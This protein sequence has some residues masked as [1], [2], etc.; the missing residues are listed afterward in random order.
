M[1]KII[2]AAF[3]A[4][5]FVQLSSAQAKLPPAAQ[6]VADRAQIDPRTRAYIS[7]QRIVWKYDGDGSLVQRPEYLL[8]KGNGQAD[9]NSTGLCVMKSTANEFPSILLDYGT[10]LQ[11][12][13]Q[14]VTGVSSAGGPV[15]VRIRFGES[16]S[17]AMA[18]LGGPKNATN[19][20]A[21]RDFTIKVPWIGSIEV[22]NSGFR[23]VRIDL[24]E[25]NKELFLKD[26]RAIFTYRDIPYIGSFKS[27]DER[28]N[29][30]WETG[31]YTV[32]VNMQDFLLEGIKRDR[33]IWQ[34]DLYPEIRCIMTVFG[35]NEVV[36]KS[37]D[38][39][40]E[41]TPLPAWMSGYSAYSLWWL[42]NQ[43]DWY[44][45]NGDLEYLRKQREYILGLLDVVFSKIDKDGTEKLDGARF[46]DW[47]T[48]DKPDVIHSG[49]Q[50]LMALT[51][52]A[53]VDIC[54]ALGETDMAKKCAD[55]AKLLRSKT[56]DAHNSKQAAALLSLAGMQDA[57]TMGDILAENGAEGFSTFY[58]YLMLQGLAKAGDYQE[59]LDCI[60]QYW[61]GMLDLGATT[62]WEDFD[63][64]WMENAGRIDELVP[65]GKVDVH[66]TYG[67]Y[68]Y[69]G[70]RNSLCHGWASGCTAWL[71]EHVLGVEVL[72]PGCKTVRITPHLGDLI[73]VEGSYPTP[74]GPIEIRH[75][76]KENG[77]IVSKINAPRGVKVIK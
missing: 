31:A 71:S 11:G 3:I 40:R 56:P 76:K 47:P 49:L 36:P 74:Y 17:E 5:C 14:L 8:Q 33:L 20:H 67:D 53:S 25:P 23:F 60:R 45:Q 61:G 59:A 37:L 9:L 16:V 63:L 72:E 21:I 48:S 50:A 2:I 77:K 19:D 18:E 7:P 51:M 22:G 10:E 68:C 29:K 30:I 66:A 41:T 52:D 15:T 39:G 43:R 58:G 73:W 35:E 1:K 64:K 42:I 27:N 75:E 28:L 69:K 26:A 70:F 12:G 13:I 44:K 62:F 32:H 46:L 4:A 65:E 38:H 55:K 54:N 24:V 34:G 57:K 6:K